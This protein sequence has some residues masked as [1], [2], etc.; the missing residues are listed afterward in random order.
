[1]HP[2]YKYDT[3][4]W[5]NRRRRRPWCDDGEPWWQQGTKAD[6][7]KMTQNFTVLH[8][9]LAGRLPFPALSDAARPEQKVGRA[10]ENEIDIELGL[11]WLKEEW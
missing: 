11:I 10:S 5:Y 4:W 2:Q 3:E 6:R 7:E 9:W 1:M 8:P